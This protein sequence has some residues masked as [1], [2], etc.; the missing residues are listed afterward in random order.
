MLIL[1]Y[2]PYGDLLGYL[3][4]SRGL[5]DKYYSSAENC[6]Q[7]VTSYDLLSFAQ[8]IS[9]GMSFLASKKVSDLCLFSSL[10]TRKVV[11]NAQCIYKPRIRNKSGNHQCFMPGISINAIAATIGMASTISSFSKNHS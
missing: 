5:E 3:R 4:K 6:Q 10:I 7:E 1:E 9:A 11:Y 8:Q 2:A